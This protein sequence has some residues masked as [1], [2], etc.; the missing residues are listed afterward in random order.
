MVGPLSNQRIQ[1]VRPVAPA[2]LPGGGSGG[3]VKQLIEVADAAVA[4]AARD[5]QDGELRGGKQPLSS[6]WIGWA[7]S[8]PP[9]TPWFC[10]CTPS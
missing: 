2:V 4:Q 3:G 8:P 9:N 6:M 10:F 7:S 5:V 1:G